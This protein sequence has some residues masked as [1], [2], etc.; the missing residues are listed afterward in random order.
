MIATWKLFIYSIFKIERTIPALTMK[1]GKKIAYLALL[2]LV[3]A[4][5]LFANIFPVLEL[6]E[7]NG[8]Q[9]AQSIPAFQVK[10]GE[11]SQSESDGFVNKT[12]LITFAYDP[13]NQISDQE[14][15]NIEKKPKLV[16]HAQKDQVTIAALNQNYQLPYQDL[17]G[18]G[19]DLNQANSQALIRQLTQ[20]TGLTMVLLFAS[21]YISS[22]FYVAFLA[23]MIS[24][25]AQILKLGRPLH[26]N[27]A[28]RFNLGLFSMT[29]SL[30]V[31]SLLNLLGLMVPFQSEL[32]ILLALFRFWIMT[33]RTH[34]VKLSEDELKAKIKEIEK[35][36]DDKNK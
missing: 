33:L 13:K 26:L 22:F 14:M 30:V 16:I 8:E 34:V 6:I 11:I 7:D 35:Y 19:K 4:A 9:V 23:L 10:D 28:D 21:L 5:A 3:S 18:Q 32:I 1:L 17:A 20:V 29:Q 12:D 24:L 31:F 2:T 36:F 15:Q 25:I 27:F